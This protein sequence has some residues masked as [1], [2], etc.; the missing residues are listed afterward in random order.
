MWYLGRR[1]R[2]RRSQD[3]QAIWSE[4]ITGDNSRQKERRGSHVTSNSRVPVDPPRPADTRLPI[5]DPELVET[6]DIFHTTS[7]SNARR[8]SANDDSWIIGIGVGIVAIVLSNCLAV[9]LERKSSQHE[10]SLYTK[11]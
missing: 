3:C 4:L 9:H 1:R 8:S 5:D 11:G 6:E 7:H 2:S 10:Y